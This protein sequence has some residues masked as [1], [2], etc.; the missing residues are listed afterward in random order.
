MSFLASSSTEDALYRW[1]GSAP[2]GVQRESE[3]PQLS[4]PRD[5]QIAQSQASG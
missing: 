2:C 3:T 1:H 4:L 5:E